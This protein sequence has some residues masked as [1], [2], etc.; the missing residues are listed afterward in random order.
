ML[1]VF[2][3]ETGDRNDLAYLGFSILT[4]NALFYPALKQQ[5]HSIIDGIEWDPSYLF[6]QSKGCSKVQVGK[7]VEAASKILALNIASGKM[8]GNVC[9]S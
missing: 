7:R 3:D 2:V 6:S 8:S 4:I 9:L 1:L 5:I